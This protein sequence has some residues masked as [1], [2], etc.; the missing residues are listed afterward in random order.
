MDIETITDEARSLLPF[1]VLAKLQMDTPEMRRAH[2][3]ESSDAMTISKCMT[4]EEQSYI[5]DA[6][7]NSEIVLRH[8]QKLQKGETVTDEEHKKAIAAYKWLRHSVLIDPSK[9]PPE[10][11]HPWVIAL[12]RA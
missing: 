6:Y 2:E 8:H 4:Q 10:N 7:Q 9:Q 3:Q 1:D 12:F 5:Q 11:I